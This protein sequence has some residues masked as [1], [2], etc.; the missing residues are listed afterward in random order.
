M[1]TMASPV[2]A[3]STLLIIMIAFF[4]AQRFLR[5]FLD[6]DQ[7]YYLRECHAHLRDGFASA[8]VWVFRSATCVLAGGWAAFGDCINVFRKDVFVFLS[9]RG[10]FGSDWSPDQLHRASR[11]QVPLSFLP[12]F[13]CCYSLLGWP[14]PAAHAGTRPYFRPDRVSPGSGLEHHVRCHPFLRAIP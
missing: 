5:V 6:R 2:F 14:F 10:R 12:G 9:S 13:H 8:L 7:Y 3:F 11:R 1:E 4:L